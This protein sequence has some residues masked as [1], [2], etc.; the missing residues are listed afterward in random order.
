MA[1]RETLT[2]IRREIES[3]LGEQVVLKTNKGRKKIKVRQGV[4]EDAFPS[5]FT[6]RLDGGTFSERRISY[7]YCDVL[8]ETVEI[9]RSN[10]VPL[11]QTTT[12]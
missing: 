2:Q 9:S 11:H 8:T 6:V 1:T 10:T 4:I 7:S 5:V 3:Y 12:I